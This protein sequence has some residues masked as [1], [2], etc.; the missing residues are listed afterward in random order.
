MGIME[1]NSTVELIGVVRK[2]EV[3]SVQVRTAVSS[4]IT[5]F[6]IREYVES[7]TYQGPTRKGIELT[8]A[9]TARLVEILE[10]TLSSGGVNREGK[11]DDLQMEE[12]ELTGSIAIIGAGSGTET[13]QIR[14]VEYKVSVYVDIRVFVDSE[15]YQGP[16]RKGIRL[17]DNLCSEV[18]SILRGA[19]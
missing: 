13:L 8:G 18:I 14:K 5:Y 2:N 11:V 19:A 3:T 6:D 12:A 9:E 10:H 17:R 1:G 16:T 4:G 15:G 7:E